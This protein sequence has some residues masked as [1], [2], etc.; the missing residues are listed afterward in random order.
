MLL[1]PAERC[2]ADPLRYA[3]VMSL[4]TDPEYLIYQMRK[5]MLANGDTL[6]ER[7]I[8]LPPF[9]D[10]EYIKCSLARAGGGS[11]LGARG[12]IRERTRRPA[13]LRSDS[14]FA[15]TT[16]ATASVSG[17]TPRQAF[18][19]VRPR[20][21]SRRTRAAPDGEQADLRVLLPEAGRASEARN[22]HGEGVGEATHE[23]P[24]VEHKPRD[25][26]RH[27]RPPPD[28]A[29]DGEPNETSANEVVH[30]QRLAT[31]EM[32]KHRLQQMQTGEHTLRPTGESSQVGAEPAQDSRM[33]TDAGGGN[34]TDP[35]AEEESIQKGSHSPV[36]STLVDDQE[37]TSKGSPISEFISDPSQPD[38][39]ARGTSERDQV[40]EEEPSTSS[41]R[42][43]EEIEI[44]AESVEDLEPIPDEYPPDA[45]PDQDDDPAQLTEASTEAVEDSQSE[46]EDVEPE[47]PAPA[48]APPPDLFEKKKLPVY[49]VP[50]EHGLRRQYSRLGTPSVPIVPKPVSALTALFQEQNRSDN[51]FAKDYSYFSGKGNA[52]PI[53]LKI[54]IPMSD[55]PESPLSISVLRDASVEEVIGYALY[56]YWTEGRQPIIPANMRDVIMWNMRI[57]EDDGLIDED[58]P[59]LER[60][61]KISKFAFDQFALCEASADQ[62]KLYETNA[63]KTPTSSTDLLSPLSPL[64]PSRT[65]TVFLKVHLY[66][67][68]DVKQTTTMPVASN[69]PLAEIFESICRKRKYDPSKYVFKMA[70]TQT[71]VPL[72]KTL[73]ML[74]VSELCILKRAGGGAGDVFL[75]PPD[76]KQAVIEHPHFIEPDEYSSMYKQYN[77]IHKA[78]MG[79]TLDRILTID[80]DHIHIM[81]GEQKNLFNAMKTASHHISSVISCKPTS[82][83]GTS[84]KLTVHTNKNDSR[85]Y[86][87]E[88]ATESEA[89]EICTKITFLIQMNKRESGMGRF[90]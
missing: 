22:A 80:G 55:D 39:S 35:D 44:H 68:I 75:R 49:K 70:D 26:L 66:S 33:E 82:K 4:I 88:A 73:E 58:F 6:S 47:P 21:A 46:E 25:P 7:I 87:L 32:L 56:E 5:A 50:E 30:E 34:E 53:Q 3:A 60:T 61:R 83:K 10:N 8:T 90:R 20:S 18:E 42:E 59:A 69:I 62:V 23:N 67:T 65:T 31:I 85:S 19:Q 79:R 45:T 36:P 77:V 29:N 74:R 63:R 9:P 43:E 48:P 17:N 76:E 41:R 14:S 27:S 81:A 78:F 72:D 11:S 15:T 51:P 28:F 38:E 52:D 86:E 54:F 84:F 37:A 64:S 40:S 16:T 12:T 89:A 71:D 2:K 13:P 1:H 57:V 24:P